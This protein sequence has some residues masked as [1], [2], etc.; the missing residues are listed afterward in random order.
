MDAQT[1]SFCSLFLKLK[2]PQEVKQFLDDLL[3]PAELK[4]VIERWEIIKRLAAGKS[5]R[6]VRDEL[7]TGI[8]TVTRGA[9][10]LKKGSGGFA[11]ML[12]KY[13]Q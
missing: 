10:A 5:Q 8:M 4:T 3:T 2:S 6:Q 11:M 7:K 1:R 13:R 9:A 12:K